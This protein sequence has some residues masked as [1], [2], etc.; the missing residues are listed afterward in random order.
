MSEG[1]LQSSPIVN[2]KVYNVVQAVLTYERQV[3]LVGN[4][5]GGPDLVWSLPGGRLEPG[6]QCPEALVREVQEET[7]LVIQPGEFLYV[8]DSRSEQDH[9]HY[10]TC[11][12]E[13]HLVSAPTSLPA[14]SSA[15]DVAVKAVRW[16]LFEDVAGIIGSRSLGEGLINYLYY[17]AAKLPRR[18]WHYPE[19]LSTED[20]PLTWPPKPAS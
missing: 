20:G 16:V 12:F 4:D 1:L 19:Y 10:L 18:Y 17:G 15:Q 3:L 9:R 13:G 8:M 14:V 11:V 6:E 2:W 5:Y 7:G